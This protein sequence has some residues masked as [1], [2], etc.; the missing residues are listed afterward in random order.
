MQSGTHPQLDETGDEWTPERM[1][2]FFE[3][4][5]F[6]LREANLLD[7]FE[8]ERWADHLTE[9]VEIR[10][11]VRVARDAGSDRPEYSDSNHHLVVGHRDLLER[12]A[13]LEKEYAWAEN[14]RSRVRH[15]IGN[16]QLGEVTADTVEVFNNQVVYRERGTDGESDTI[17]ARRRSHLRETDEGF[18]LADRDVFIDHT[19]VP[20]RNLTLP[21]L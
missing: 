10:V 6:L 9:D 20:S 13:R 17:S 12:V 15:T 4:R 1:Q 8:L 3:V 21:L 16:V 7:Q 14:P 2:R 5:E 18:A 11:P 19:I